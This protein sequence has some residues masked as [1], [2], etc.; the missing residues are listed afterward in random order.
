MP[1]IA[2]SAPTLLVV[3][4]ALGPIVA[5]SL[6]G[7]SYLALLQLRVPFEFTNFAAMQFTASHLLH[8]SL[9]RGDSWWPMWQAHSTL[10]GNNKNALYETL[11]FANQVRLQHPPMSPLPFDLLSAFDFRTFRALNA[12][13]NVVCALNAAAGL[14]AWLLFLLCHKIRRP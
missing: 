11:F 5:V 7:W 2:P 4:C 14:L 1:N 8:P 10:A 6:L 3:V 9:L 12:I 13:K